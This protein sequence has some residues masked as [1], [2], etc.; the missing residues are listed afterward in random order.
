MQ[1]HYH[2]KSD[3]END[4]RQMT[5]E[6]ESWIRIRVGPLSV[7]FI[8]NLYTLSASNVTCYGLDDKTF[9]FATTSKPVLDSTQSPI[10]CGPCAFLKGVKRSEHEAGHSHQSN[11]EVNNMWRFTGR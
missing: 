1:P 10:Q 2:A 7:N 4:G 6:V 11:D 8:S 9:V 5:Y 3:C